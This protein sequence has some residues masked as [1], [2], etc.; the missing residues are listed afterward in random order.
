MSTPNSPNKWSPYPDSLLDIARDASYFAEAEARKSYAE[1][2]SK[3]R[4]R[5]VP[6]DWVPVVDES[7]L[8]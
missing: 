8:S 5:R 3:M 1:L 6:R 2:M 4:E 7:V